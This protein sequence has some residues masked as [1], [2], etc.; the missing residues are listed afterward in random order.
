LT[1]GLI[2]GASIIGGSL[3]LNSSEKVMDIN[4]HAFGIGTISLTALLGI[5]GYVIATALGLWLIVS[6][7]FSR[8]L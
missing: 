2:I 4:V 6:I 1:I 5:I 8:K 3:A 7:I